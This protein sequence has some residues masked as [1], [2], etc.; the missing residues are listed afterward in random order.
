MPAMFAE[1]GKLPSKCRM[2][3]LGEREGGRRRAEGDG[4]VGKHRGALVLVRRGDDFRY[5]RSGAMRGQEH[6]IRLRGKTLLFGCYYVGSELVKAL[7]LIPELREPFDC[8][9]ASQRTA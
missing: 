9:I 4:G 1:P 6:S 3:E 5:D 7:V 2:V 8:G